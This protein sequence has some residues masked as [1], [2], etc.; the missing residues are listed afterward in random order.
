MA[1]A[2]TRVPFRELPPVTRARALIAERGE[3]VGVLAAMIVAAFSFPHLMPAAVATLGTLGGLAL[4]LHALGLMLVYRTDGIINF[5]QV[6]IGAVG[7]TFFVLFARYVPVLT[8]IRRACPSC[9]ERITPLEYRI[10]YV[11]AAIGGLLV[12]ILMGWLIS[13]L[14]MRRFANA[15]RLIP[16]VAT[17]FL[18]PVL[19]LAQRA[20]G[21]GLVT[22]E[23]REASGGAVT[24]GAP[25]SPSRFSFRWGPAVFGLPQILLA[26]VVVV[27]LA[28]VTYYLRRTRSGTSLRAVADNPSRAAT[29]GINVAK[30]KNR[31]WVIA[32]AL[33]GAAS[34]LA[35]MT[36]GA[37]D[38]GALGV[39][40]TVR[41]LAAAVIARMASLPAAVAAAAALGLFET[42]LDWSFNA[43]SL[44]DGLL[45]VVIVVVLFA[46]RA[47]TTRAEREAGSGWR[48]APE[49]RPIPA[50]LRSHATVKTWIRW[51]AVILAVATLGYPSVMSSSQVSLGIA[52]LLA[53]IV[54][55][56]LLVLTGWAGQI[57][58][59]QMGFAAVGAYVAAASRAPLPLAI[60]IGT[61]GGALIAVVVGIP[62]LR[63][64]GMHLAVATLAFSLATSAVLLDERRLGRFLPASVTRPRVLLND[65][66]FYYLALGILALAVI[67]VAGL[68]RSRFARVLIGAR[69]NEEGAQSYGISIVRARI[70]AFAISGGLAALAG[71][72]LAFQ[73]LGVRT[74]TFSPEQS[75][76]AFLWVV[77]GGLG[78]VSGPLF[79]AAV[80]A[81]VNIFANNQLVQFIAGG[82]GGLL[83]LI[84]VPGGI[85]RMV[86]G[87]RDSML[88]RL[89]ERERIIVP[90]LLADLKLAESDRRVSIAPLAMPVEWPDY[91]VEAQ[92]ALSGGPSE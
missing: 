68:R 15:A 20:L 53:A 54:G 28:A 79:G 73:Q 35:A 80:H 61:L 27:A 76:Y 17:L 3:I 1:T 14:V 10:N 83:L 89:A 67:A 81:I 42:S 19:G 12:S 85:A 50:E 25:T 66:A 60:V 34:I 58:L 31:A 88:R 70:V 26:V 56:S 46:Q 78:A 33:S 51:G 41:I 18:V 22:Q 49:V 86:F 74:E 90:S 75:L 21:N 44:L 29:L 13:V 59:G 71:A 82:A 77:I 63:L 91:E 37:P 69:D 2:T 87:A 23:Q 43:A 65:R 39:Q 6:Q 40:T 5:A 52:A 92:W 72:L 64:R 30:V 32:A 38:A 48:F 9:I 4:G 8:A 62:A 45:L 11:F 55:L 47:R 7:A 16:T 84:A 57:S 36:A 24:L